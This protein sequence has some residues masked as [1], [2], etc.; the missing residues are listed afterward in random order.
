MFKFNLKSKQQQHKRPEEQVSIYEEL[1]KLGYT[2]SD[3]REA[4]SGYTP[5]RGFNLA[6]ADT[7]DGTPIVGVTYACDFRYEEEAGGAD[8]R[9][10]FGVD[11]KKHGYAMSHAGAG[12]FGVFGDLPEGAASLILSVR[13]IARVQSWGH[14][15]GREPNAVVS[16]RERWLNAVAHGSL[17]RDPK[18]NGWGE[19]YDNHYANSLGSIQSLPE[20]R[21]WWTIPEIKAAAVKMGIPGPFPRKKAELVDYVTNHPVRLTAG[22]DS[23]DWPGWFHYGDVLVLRADR[24]IVA[25]TLKLLV[26]AAENETLAFGG[27]AQIFGSGMSLYD[28]MDVGPVLEQE[29]REAA[30]WYDAE[31][32]KLEPVKEELK[33]RGFGW[34]ALGNPHLREDG[35][36]QYWLNGHGNPQPFGWYTREE[37]LAERFVADAAKARS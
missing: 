19:Y 37:L 36:T 29:R 16:D 7:P 34:Y 26:R 10:A 33:R 24:G 31:M 23:N 12:H 32:K 28:G 13:P 18:N 2:D 25:D 20:I 30:A 21:Q 8:I 4:G 17:D 35:Q 22:S 3:I 14:D 11:S 1:L 5:A 9:E 15:I 27:G 6:V